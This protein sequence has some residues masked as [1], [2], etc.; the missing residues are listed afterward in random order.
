VLKD[1][2]QKEFPDTDLQ[3][4]AAA[5]SRSGGFLGQA[6]ALLQE[7]VAVSPQTEGFVHS[8]VTRD[9]LLLASTLV[10]MEK[11]K[12]DQAIAEWQL[13]LQLLQSALSAQA[14][15]QTVSPLARQLSAR[16]GADLMGAIQVL[17]KVIEY[18]QGNVSVAAICG[19]LQYALR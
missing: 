18:A 2:L 9:K 13:W 8:F 3:S 7:G 14:G 5:I 15:Q 4:L 11:W 10:G 16:G 6:K 1:A 12:R 19:Y 17:K